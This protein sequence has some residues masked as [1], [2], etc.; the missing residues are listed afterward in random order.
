MAAANTINLNRDIPLVAQPT[1]PAEEAFSSKKYLAVAIVVAALAVAILPWCLPVSISLFSLSAW[2]LWSATIVVLN[3][4]ADGTR[5]EK[6]IHRLHALAT[7][8]NSV[9]GSFF[10]YPYTFFQSF[11]AAKGNLKGRPILMVHG[12]VSFG[13]IWHDLREKMVEKG[14]GPIYTMNVGSGNS[15]KSY[16]KDIEARVEE[17][18]KET[19]RKDLV[20]IGHSKG[21][22]VSS[23]FATHAD[24]TKTTVTDVITIGSP[25]AGTPMAH[26]GI[27]R[28]AYEMRPE[29]K[30]HDEL[31]QK[32]K[33]SAHIRFSHIASE[34]DDIVPFSSAFFSENR[35][36]HFAVKDMGHLG[37]VFSSRVADQVCTWLKPTAQ[38][39]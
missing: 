36:R 29:H 15:I 4:V 14:F 3:R 16:A 1:L 10:L 13:A 28:D 26:Y 35:A 23:Y 9:V 17:I 27:G 21:G 25:L 20:L 39:T 18:Q 11:H 8:V 7:E 2:Y 32:I 38:T 12:Y 33:E 19:G 24:Q 6:I 22:L 37:L 5:L 34:Q 30:F 31:R